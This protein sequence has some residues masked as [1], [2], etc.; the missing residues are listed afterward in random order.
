MGG[1]GGPD[2]ASDAGNT[3]EA[4]RLYRQSLTIAERLARLDP[5]NTDFQRDLAVFYGR[6]A[7]L[8]SDGADTAGA[9]S[10]YR[11]ALDFSRQ[12]YGIDHPLTHAIADA[13]SKVGENKAD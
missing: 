5:D 8:A 10:I 9:L 4:E 6:L 7:S 12:V 2:L 1:R 11:H 13:A 3:G